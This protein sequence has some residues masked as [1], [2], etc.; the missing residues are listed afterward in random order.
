LAGQFGIELDGVL[1]GF[2]ESAEG[3]GA[4]AD[5]ITERVGVDGIA[6]KHLAGVKYEDI[7]ITCGAGMSPA[8]FK[9]VADAFQGRS[10]RRNGA[11]VE[12]DYSLSQ[13]SRLE[14]S[15]AIITEVGLPALDASSKDA[16][17]MT[18]KFSP[19][20]TRYKKSG[21][22]ANGGLT[23]KAKAWTPAN[24]RLVISGLDCTR[25]ARV[26]AITVKQT[27]VDN[28]VGERRDYEKA[29]V[30]PPE[31]PILVVTLAETSA[32][33]WVDWHEN[34]VING[35]SGASQEKNGTLEYLMPNSTPLFSIDLVALGIFRL[36][37]GGS[38]S[39]SDK[40]RRVI[41]EMYC[42]TMSFSYTAGAGTGDQ[43]KRQPSDNADGGA[44]L[45]ALNPTGS[46]PG[47]VPLTLAQSPAT[48][49]LI[50]HAPQIRFRS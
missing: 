12:Y 49:P 45:T 50:R 9:A 21:G 24:F 19:E 41:A 15:N 20:T 6:H 29:A 23:G 43:P 42:E 27:L 38:S 1:Q 8:F 39:G 33:S 35:N 18:I 26:E 13:L 47:P 48:Q 16:A 11:I 30:A 2:V 44:T 22:R 34:F 14:F 25:V 10:S 3:G 36:T 46:A 40:I 5:V 31:V 4:T 32:Q 17:R 28:A 7:V 37:R